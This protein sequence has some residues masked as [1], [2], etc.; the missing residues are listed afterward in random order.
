MSSS[1]ATPAHKNDATALVQAVDAHGSTSLGTTRE[2]STFGATLREAPTDSHELR[3]SRPAGADQAI[4]RRHWLTLLAFC[5]N[6]ALNSFG[7]V[8]F[9]VV[10]KITRDSL[11]IGIHDKEAVA[12]FYTGFLLTVCVG[13]VPGMVMVVRYE[14][15]ALGFSVVMNVGCT[16]VRWLGVSRQDYT[17][18]LASVIIGGAGAWPILTLPSQLSQ[19]FPPQMAAFTTSLAVQANYA[20]WLLGSVIPPAVVSDP[21]SM[22]RFMFWQAIGSL[23]VIVAYVAFYSPQDQQERSIIRCCGTRENNLPLLS[24]VAEPQLARGRSH[25]EISSAILSEQG[26]S[27]DAGRDVRVHAHGA[28]GHGGGDDGGVYQLLRCYW[29]YPRFGAQVLAYGLLGGVSFA[30][31]GCDDELL[32]QHGFNPKVVSFV[33]VAFLATGIVCGILLGKKVADPRIYGKVLKSL[34]VACT[35]SLSILAVL[36]ETGVLPDTPAPSHIVLVAV[37]FSVVGMSSLGFIGV[38]IE[39]AALYPCGSAYVCF[40]IE[41]LLQ[42]FGALLNQISLNG[43]GFAI[44]AG[45]AWL[46]TFFLLAGYHRYRADEECLA[47]I[48]QA[49]A[50]VDSSVSARTALVSELEAGQTESN[51]DR[52]KEAV[53]V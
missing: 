31:P 36:F 6:T 38:G 52:A 34:F 16:W 23:I 42:V 15:V 14:G 19:R 33:N 53:A 40:S 22:T 47:N 41:A 18:C 13:M 3:E 50:E 48:A 25:H 35:V 27:V 43:R 39:A 26:E 30:L 37:L 45:A 9:A 11:H 44:I 24:A 51:P 10:Q 32:G 20:G 8:N 7:S 49:D 21:E 29:R 1:S 46:G 2:P 28:H 4:P 5:L 17:L 12:W